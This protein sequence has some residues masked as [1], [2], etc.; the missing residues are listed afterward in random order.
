MTIDFLDKTLPGEG[1]LIL[2]VFE[3]QKLT[4]IAAEADQKCHGALSRAIIAKEFK[5]KGSAGLVLERVP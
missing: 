5:G 2:G 1:T 3:D 4:G